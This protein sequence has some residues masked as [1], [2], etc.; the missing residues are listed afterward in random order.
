M[1]YIWTIPYN[2]TYYS[3]QDNSILS[4]HNK[5]T[6]YERSIAHRNYFPNNRAEIS[7]F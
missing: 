1:I 2:W 3:E 6:T 7:G 4:L 5:T